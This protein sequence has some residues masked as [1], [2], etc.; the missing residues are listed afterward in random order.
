MSGVSGNRRAVATSRG[1]PMRMGATSRTHVVG[2][3][4]WMALR[5]SAM[6]PPTSSTKGSAKVL[7]LV[8]QS[9][10][11]RGARLLLEALLL[12]GKIEN[13]AALCAGHR[14][15]G[16][17]LPGGGLEPCAAALRALERE[18][19]LSHRCRPIICCTRASRGSAGAALV[20]PTLFAVDRG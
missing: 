1:A 3:Y 16:P 15:V 11:G 19:D 14:V 6:T 18:L 9:L 7:G 12:R 5:A 17:W 8:P 10:L 20:A 4:A 2:S 13:S